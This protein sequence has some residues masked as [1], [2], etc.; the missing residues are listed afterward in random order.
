[1]RDAAIVREEQQRA[2][3]DC[4]LET[5]QRAAKECKRGGP[6]GTR[7]DRSDTS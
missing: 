2:R 5:E 4:S 6:D 3:S 7:I 1:M